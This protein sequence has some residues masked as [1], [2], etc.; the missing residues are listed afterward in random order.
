MVNLQR[1]NLLGIANSLNEAVFNQ[2]TWGNALQHM[3]NCFGGS[4]AT[5]EIFNKRTGQHAQH[6]DSSDIQIRE[7]YVSH[8][9]PLNPR[10]AFGNLPDAPNVMHDHLFMGENDMDRCEFYADFLSEFDLR[11]FLALKVFE[12]KEE[13]GVF[14][15]QK[16]ASSGGATYDEIH[17]I[18]H[19]APFLQN[20]AKFQIGQGP[21]FQRLND[22]ECLLELDDKGVLFLDELGSVTELNSSATNILMANDGLFYSNGKL[23]CADEKARKK[24]EFALLKVE[25]EIS[26]NNPGND[27]LV[28][29]PSGLPPYQL[30]VQSVGKNIETLS[31]SGRTAFLVLIK[32]PVLERSIALSELVDGLGLT[33]AEA[34]V[35]LSIAKGQTAH[36]IA[37]YT[38]VSIPTVRTH[39]QRVMQKMSVNKQADIV[40]TLAQY[41]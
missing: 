24:L 25:E 21:L 41:L 31:I 7:E 39:I 16:N 30:R 4:F 27:V 6:L 34:S 29:R 13:F 26:L 12:S 20:I 37:L 5:F 36:D 9:M 19:L 8:Y 10:I 18:Q 3:A 15:I 2:N 14:T 38:G 40:R 33:L 32:D 17:A 22:L 35:A 23:T 11:Y 1:D 28:P